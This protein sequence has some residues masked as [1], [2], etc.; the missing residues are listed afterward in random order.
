M[1]VYKDGIEKTI[2]E[3]QWQTYKEKG[4]IQVNTK[5]EVQPKQEEVIEVDEFTISKPKAKK[6]K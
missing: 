6:K 4:F 5:P 2:R 1:Q 3:S